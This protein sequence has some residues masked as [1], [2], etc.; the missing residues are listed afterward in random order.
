M[1]RNNKKGFTLIEILIAVSISVVLAI[2]V[3]RF[4]VQGY[5]SIIFSS[6]QEEAVGVAR[7]AL[8][9]IVTEIRSANSSEQGAYALLN[10]EEQDFIFY[11][12]VDNDGETEKVRYFL[13]NS[14]LKRVFTEPGLLADYSEAGVTST[15]A[16]Y[17]NNQDDPIFIYYD[18]EHSE[19]DAINNI[20][21]I[22]V[23]LEVN[24]TP[25]RAAFV[26]ALPVESVIQSA[27]K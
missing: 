9:I 20:R 19:V 2:V 14:E 17:I 23:Q 11:G 22:N 27:H 13:E 12:D 10:I 24:V 6:E 1:R 5:K 25:E 26:R 7:D 16:S 8:E 15:I 3:N 21:L 4:I 18:S